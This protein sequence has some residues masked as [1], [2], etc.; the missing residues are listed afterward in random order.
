[1]EKIRKNIIYTALII[2]SLLTAC[3]SIDVAVSKKVNVKSKIKKIAVFPFVIHGAKWGDE[4][5]DSISHHFFKKGGIE[6]VER[7]ALQKI[8]KEQSLSASGA[9]D[10]DK[11]VEIGKMIGADLIIL[12]RGSA[13]NLKKGIILKDKIPNLIDTF[14][15]KAIDVETGSMIITVRKKPG[16]EWDTGYRLKYCCG[17]TLIWSGNDILVESS[18]YDEIAEKIVDRIL[19]ALRISRVN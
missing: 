17:L 3:S 9:I 2:M 1:M 8:L 16:K 7:D 6:I 19:N 12:G 5:A 10:Q 14:S 18:N 11:A 15:L 13:L 4:F